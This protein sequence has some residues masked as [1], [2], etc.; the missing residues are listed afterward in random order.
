[1][2]LIRRLFRKDHAVL[3]FTLDG[4]SCEGREGDTLLTAV[5][6][7]GEVLRISEFLQE[8]RAGFC[9]MGACQDCWMSLESGERVRAC[10]TPLQAGLR[11]VTRRGRAP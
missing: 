3:R 2:P 1:M 7:G 5:L 6:S 8:P 9:Q 10:T 4:A 11:V